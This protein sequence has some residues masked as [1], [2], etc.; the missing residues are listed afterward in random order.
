M[1]PAFKMPA[2]SPFTAC[3]VYLMGPYMVHEVRL[4]KVCYKVQTTCYTCFS[5]KACTI[6]LLTGYWAGDFL[7]AHG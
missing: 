1:L 3:E 6:V 4:R 7:R 2:C 5:S